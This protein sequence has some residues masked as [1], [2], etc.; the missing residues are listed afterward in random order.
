MS[1]YP[2]SENDPDTGGLWFCLF[3][4]A[5]LLLFLAGRFS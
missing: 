5:A 4:G 2:G 1:R 3:V